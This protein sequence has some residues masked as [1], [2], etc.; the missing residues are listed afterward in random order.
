MQS[1]RMIPFAPIRFKRERMSHCRRRARRIA[2]GLALLAAVAGGAGAATAATPAPGNYARRPEVRAFIAELVADEG[3]S[4]RALQG[5]FTHARYQPRVIAAI[6]RPVVSPPQWYE[7]A[8]RFLTPERVAA[9]GG[10]LARPRRGARA[11]RARVRRAAG[12]DRGDPRRRDLLRAQRWQLPGIRC[13]D[14]ARLRLSAT[15]CVL[16]WRAQGI[17]A[18][19]PGAGHLAA[20]GEGIVCRGDGPGAI[21]AGQHPQLW[22]GLQCRRSHR[23]VRRYRRR[24]RQRRALPVAPRLAAR[25]AAHGAGADRGHGCAGGRAARVRRRAYRPA[26]A[27]RLGGGGHHRFRH[28][29]RPRT[30]S[31]RIA[32]ARGTRRTELLAGLQQLVRAHPLQPEPAVRGGGERT[33]AGLARRSRERR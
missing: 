9:G 30:R 12:S 15:R 23:S 4:A 2:A 22:A 6:S 18:A 32:H 7:Y 21:H 20:R 26:L 16:P 27:R 1:R 25:S 29:R 17:P 10:V 11:R 13:A 19:L 31:G 8:P 28:S 14:H 24:H 3:F 5:L 33:G